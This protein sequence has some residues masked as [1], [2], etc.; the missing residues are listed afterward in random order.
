MAGSKSEDK[1]HKLVRPCIDLINQYDPD[2]KDKAVR[3]E[4]KTRCK[5]KLGWKDPEYDTEW[6]AAPF[7]L[8]GLKRFLERHKRLPSEKEREGI[9]LDT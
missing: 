3:D 5:L 9:W 4:L 8:E 6:D 7:Y 2:K 1:Y